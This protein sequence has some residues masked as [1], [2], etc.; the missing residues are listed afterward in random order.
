MKT[1]RN[2]TNVLLAFVM[3]GI[4]L[5]SSCK[6][7]D[8]DN[9]PA[10]LSEDQINACVEAATTISTELQNSI[11]NLWSEALQKGFEG[12][13]VPDL[14]TDQKSGRIMTGYSGDYSWSGPDKQGWYTRHSTYG[15]GYDYTEKLRVTSDTVIHIL[16]ISY[17]GADAQVKNETTTKYFKYTKNNKVMYKGY[18]FWDWDVSGY[19]D[20]SRVQWKITFNDWNPDTGAGVYEWWIGVPENS[21]GDTYPLYRYLYMSATESANKMLHVLTKWFDEHGS[22]VWEWEYDTTYEPVDMPDTPEL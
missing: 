20:N 11:M 16:T 21:G 3:G 15:Y 22:T 6:K 7:E 17:D 19:G 8:K 10:K 14:N 4:L 12:G 9:A 1:F 5:F 13:E 18:S 2:L